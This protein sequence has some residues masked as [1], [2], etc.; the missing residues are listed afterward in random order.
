MRK[1][2]YKQFRTVKLPEDVGPAVGAGRFTI[3]PAPERDWEMVP[4]DGQWGWC[5]LVGATLVNIL[6]PGTIKSFGVLL[7]EFYDVFETT[8]SASS[9]IVALC[10]FLYSSLGPLS[11][12]L[13][14][15]WSYRTVTL[16]GGSFAAFG[17]IAS[18]FAFC[19]TFLYFSFGAMVGMGAGL[20]FP[21]TVYIVTSYFVRLRGLANGIC[22]SGSAF[23][24]I[25]LPPVLRYLLGTYGYKGAVLILGGIMLNVWAA[26]LL[27][28]P[29]EEH[30][31]KK[32][33]EPEED[34]E[35]PQLEPFVEEE[36]GDT[37]ETGN[38]TVILTP[39]EATPTLEKHPNGSP[40][41]FKNR[42][43]ADLDEK[44][45][46]SKNENF[47][48]SA[49]AAL[50]SR[51]DIERTRKISTPASSRYGLPQLASKNHLPSNPSLLESVPEGKRSR[52]NSQE[53]FGK[54]LTV[55]KIP[56]RSPSTSSFQYMSTPFH[57]STLSAFE[58]PS[59]FA[60]QFSLKSI[61]DSLAPITYCCGFKKRPKEQPAKNEPNKYFDVHLLKD[62]I[63][64]VIL[65]SNCTSAISYTNFIILVPSYA[66][67]C[68]FDK[69]SGAYL[70][71]IISAL[72]LVGRIGG[73]A[74]SDVVNTPKRYFFI[75]GLLLSGISLALIP[76]VSSY[77]AI[78]VYCSVFGLASGINVGVTA[79]VMTEMLGTER[80]MSSY[81]ISLFVNGILQLI[82]PP[83]CGFWFE[84]TN[85]YKSLF[86]TLGFILVGGA[87]LWAWVPLIHWRRRRNRE[88][89][90]QNLGK[91]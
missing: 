45:S 14:V 77:M 35:G 30:M 9:G 8:P 66:Q 42:S 29:V 70:L 13:S 5:V 16:I 21:P 49:S 25:I 34:E 91:A 1:A 73:S 82:G 81:G 17:M 67:E 48:R 62:P 4:P 86:V 63:Y 50:V 19:I 2:K 88:R 22:M 83:I 80:L 41:I 12:I 79:L 57:G 52:V 72:D 89:I 56:K 24:S 40:P 55:P 3:G 23:G 18:S 51:V 69:S 37:E 10:Y 38:P 44:S 26:A 6:I 39:E 15:K 36:P 47:V 76:S 43:N 85:S 87:A 61:T 71:S 7:V 32:Y 68:G 65:I 27:F 84:H 59:E 31:V 28:Q 53:A 60:S 33:K 64:L 54:K 11:S 58:K 20:A 78:S 90:E 75:F 46:P 74:L